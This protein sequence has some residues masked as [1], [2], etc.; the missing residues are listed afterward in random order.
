V[1]ISST[2]ERLDGDRRKDVAALLEALAH[3][4]GD[5]HAAY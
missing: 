1:A 4:V 2:F 5:R 3:V